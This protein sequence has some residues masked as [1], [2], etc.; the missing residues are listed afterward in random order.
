M[1]AWKENIS[2]Q[3]VELVGNKAT[4]VAKVAI[5]PNENGRIHVHKTSKENIAQI[6]H[7]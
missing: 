4:V 5:N 6:F 3:F 2:T 1:S 7:A